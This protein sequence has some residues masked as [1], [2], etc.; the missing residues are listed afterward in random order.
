MHESSWYEFKIEHPYDT[1]HKNKNYLSV[2][3]DDIKQ[4]AKTELENI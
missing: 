2:G 4:L 1:P 3:T